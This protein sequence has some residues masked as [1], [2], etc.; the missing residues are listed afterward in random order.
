M[1]NASEKRFLLKLAREAIIAKINGRE[2][3]LE[4]PDNEV[5]QKKMG[6]FVTIHKNGSLR[7]CIGYV[8]AVDTIFNTVRDMAVSAAVE[9][10]RFP[11][12]SVSELK[13][14]EIE[15]SMLSKLTPIQSDKD[16][17]VG[18]DG[19]FVVQ[20]NYSGLL[21]PQVAIEYG[22]D[23]IKFLEEACRKAGLPAMAWKNSE[24]RLY[25]FRATIFSENNEIV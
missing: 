13:D 20:G 3:T 22:F 21:L 11:P 18:P 14:I 16:I 9:D 7:G 1:F 17:T 24:T 15:I 19:L 6:G 12:L 25:S 8:K 23:A 4:F 2:L 10:P 5:F